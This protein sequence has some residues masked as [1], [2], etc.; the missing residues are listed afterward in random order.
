MATLCCSAATG[1]S[2]QSLESGALSSYDLCQG[3]GAARGGRKL[4][5]SFSFRVCSHVSL[6]SRS[7]RDSRTAPEW[8]GA[9]GSCATAGK[10][11]RT[12]L[13]VGWTLHSIQPRKRNLCAL[14]C[15]FNST[16]TAE[17]MLISPFFFLVFPLLILISEKK[18]RLQNCRMST[19][20]EESMFLFPIN[21]NCPK[22]HLYSYFSKY[23]FIFINKYFITAIIKT[24][25][26]A[27]MLYFN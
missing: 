25:K 16:Q 23:T 1:C 14:C 4:P 2:E 12:A 9:Q 24:S 20:R 3:A 27:E 26:A 6:P 13:R 22:I 7:S 5:I 15:S 21:I 10:A 11:H 17:T 8:G 19:W 18:I